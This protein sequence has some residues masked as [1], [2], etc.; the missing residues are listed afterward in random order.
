VLLTK[1]IAI[2]FGPV[3]I[4]CNAICPGFVDTPLLASVLSH[5]FMADARGKTVRERALRRLGRAKEIAATA[6]R[7]HDMT[8]LMGLAGP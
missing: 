2:H 5:P 6:G 4:R 3:G 1:N 8:K 7:D